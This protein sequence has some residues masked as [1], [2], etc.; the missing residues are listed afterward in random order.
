MN[1]T[2]YCYSLVKFMTTIPTFFFIV[3]RY[4]H[5]FYMMIN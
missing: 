1:I 2:L 5:F 3:N 4:L